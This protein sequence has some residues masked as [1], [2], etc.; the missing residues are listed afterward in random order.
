[1]SNDRMGVNKWLRKQL[2]SAWPNPLREMVQTFAETLMSADADVAHG[3]PYRVVSPD[4]ITRC[5]TYRACGCDTRVGSI[6]LSISKLR[7]G[8]A[9]PW[10]GI[11]FGHDPVD[12]LLPARLSRRQRL[13]DERGRSASAGVPSYDAYGLE[14]LARA[15]TAPPVVP[16]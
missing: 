8:T 14:D 10:A 13:S 11:Q 7:E 12:V 15:S 2:E 3:A 16:P 5:N 9:S 1:M 4:R 6:G